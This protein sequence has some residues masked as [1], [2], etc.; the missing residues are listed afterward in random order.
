MKVRLL[1]KHA[2]EAQWR[3]PS[4]T[5]YQNEA[6]LQMLLSRSPEVLPGEDDERPLVLTA[7]FPVAFGY[8]DLVGV[9]ATGDLIV[10]ECKLR[11]NADIRRTVVGQLFAYAASLWGLTFEEFDERWRLTGRGPLLDDLSQAAITQGVALDP[12]AI[13]A[14][15]ED[16]LRAGRYRLIVA[17]DDITPELQRIIEYLSD[18]TLPDVGVLALELGFVADGDMQVLVPQAYGL[19]MARQKAASRGP[20]RQWDEAS[21][22]DQLEREV[23]DWA[24]PIGRAL[25]DWA[26]AQG[27]EVWYGTGVKS[28]TM[29]LG[30]TDVTG[31]R[32]ALLALYAPGGV[33]L[34]FDILKQMRAFADLAARDDVR[35]RLAAI[36]GVVAERLTDTWPSIRYD[37]LRPQRSLDTLLSVYTSVVERI[38]EVGG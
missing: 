30:L 29:S 4:V 33:T 38:R 32:R 3:V 20:G 5:A 28:A 26:V 6:E 15:V 8:I 2:G 14:A 9:S 7:E 25:H 19:E 18:H 35:T 36:E 17:V 10:V 21:F 16:N 27:L 23:G 34:Q 22:F 31:K 1:I 24:A 13:R 37:L 12:M 11:T